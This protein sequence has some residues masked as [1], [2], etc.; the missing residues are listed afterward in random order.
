MTAGLRSAATLGVLVAL[1]LLATLWGWA[2]FTEPFPKDEPVAICENATVPAGGEVRR[3]QVVVSVFNGSGRS[4]LAS[5]ASAELEE[6]GFVAGDVG[7]APDPSPTTQIW[8]DDAANPAV[9]LVRQQFKGAQVVEGDALGPGVVV[10]LG[11][12][13]QSLKKKQVESV[14]AQADA[15]YCRATG[16]E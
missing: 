1:V 16:S 13:F 5:T 9:D 2:A 4:G 14:V 12:K 10:I 6:R 7:N 8:A 3:D 15:T 11:E